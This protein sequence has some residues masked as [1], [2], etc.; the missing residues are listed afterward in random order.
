MLLGR[1]IRRIGPELLQRRLAD[2]AL[3]H[4]DD[5]LEGDIIRTVRNQ[6]HVREDIL[7]FPALVEVDT[8]DDLIRHVHLD[9]LLLE[10][11]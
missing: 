2:A 7:D 6:L 1:C 9:A 5:A 10:Q 3:R 11:S 8:T 4:V